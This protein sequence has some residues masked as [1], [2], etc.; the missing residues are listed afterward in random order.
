MLQRKTVKLKPVHLFKHEKSF[1]FLI[2]ACNIDFGCWHT[3]QPHQGRTP[4]TRDTR[5][6]TTINILLRGLCFSSSLVFIQIYLAFFCL[7][8]SLLIGHYSDLP[9]TI[10]LEE[11]AHKSDWSK[12]T[13]GHNEENSPNINH[14]YIMKQNM[15]HLENLERNTCSVGFNSKKLWCSKI[16]RCEIV[17]FYYYVKI[18]LRSKI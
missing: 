4:I 2:I 1:P 7:Y 14:P 6:E 12:T 17:R 15:V 10:S 8:I 5:D 3:I 18:L 13:G 9:Q 11:W 16:L